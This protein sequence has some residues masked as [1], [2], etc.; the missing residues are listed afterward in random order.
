MAKSQENG[1]ILCK[2]PIW[3]NVSANYSNNKPQT[4]LFNDR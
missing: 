1:T 2:Q 3:I 4:T